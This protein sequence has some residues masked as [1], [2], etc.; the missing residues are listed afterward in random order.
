MSLD[1]T[2]PPDPPPALLAEVQRDLAALARTRRRRMLAFALIALAFV[3]GA[4]LA[5]GH[6]PEGFIGPGCGSPAHTAVMIGFTALGLTLVGLAFG[7]SLP[8]GR[9]LR[10]VPALGV[11]GGLAGLGVLTALYRTPGD[12]FL[13]GA[14]C[15][16]VGAVLSLVLVAAAVAIGRR[17]LRRH[18]PTATLF[19]VGVGLLALVPLSLACHDASMSHLMVWHGLIPVAGGLIGAFAWRR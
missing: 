13:H 8:T 11:V 14:K 2:L 17:V 12:P 5:M 7:L 9:R 16:V 4:G 18:A 1:A 19:G 15:L 6:T 3:L 10:A